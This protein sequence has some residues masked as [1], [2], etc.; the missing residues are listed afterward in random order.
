MN[1]SAFA[2]RHGAALLLAALPLAAAAQNHLQDSL[3][4]RGDL[5]GARPAAPGSRAAALA[6]RPAG[7]VAATAAG[8][9]SSAS[10][11]FDPVLARLLHEHVNPARVPAEELPNLYER[12]LVATRAARRQW[13]T[14]DWDEASAALG[15]LN[16]RYEQV[17]SSLPLDERLRVRGAQGEFRTLQSARRAKDQLRERD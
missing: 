10:G 7:A 8:A 3:L 6:R 15:R 11:T 1:P 13:K 9:A 16:A 17:R 12:F 4:R 2:R 14:R 5:V